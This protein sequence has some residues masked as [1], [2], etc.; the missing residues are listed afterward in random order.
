MVTNNRLKFHRFLS[1]CICK[2]KSI[3]LRVE[4]NWTNKLLNGCTS[5]NWSLNITAD[6]IYFSLFSYTKF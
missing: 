3:E 2:Y 5:M 1:L 6:G 4:N